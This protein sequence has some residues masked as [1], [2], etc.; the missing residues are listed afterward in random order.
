MKVV[1]NDDTHT[2]WLGDKKLVSVTQLLKKHGLST[3]YTGVDDEVLKR[4]AERGTMI[5]KEI[6]TYNKTGE[7]GFTSELQDYIEICNDLEFKPDNSEI[8]LPN[9]EIDADK[10]DDYIFA[11]TADIIGHSKYGSTLVDIKTTSKVDHRACSWQ[12]SLYERLAGVVFDKFFVFHLGKDSKAVPIAKIPA[13]EIDRLLWCEKNGEIYREPGLVISSDLVAQAEQA[14]RELQI[15]EEV[16]KNAEAT[17]KEYRQKLYDLMSEQA[18]ASWETADKSML[19]TRVAPATKTTI[20]SKRLKA[21]L[22]DIAEQYGKTSEVSG[23]VKITI[24]G[25]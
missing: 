15:A 7:I 8:I 14:E 21:E 5:H 13:Q 6:E 12:L 17:A 16:R 1:F 22:P 19:V 10:L 2:Y 11:G 25:A 23:Y 9:G 4:V 3:N 18:I 20:D 24:R